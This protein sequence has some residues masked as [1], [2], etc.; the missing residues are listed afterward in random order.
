MAA[1]QRHAMDRLPG[2]YH[3]AGCTLASA[4][5]ACLAQGL[6]VEEAVRQA[7][8][9]TWQTLAAD[10][11]REWG[12]SYPTASSGLDKRKSTTEMRH[13]TRDPGRALCDHPDG[14]READL[15]ARAEATLKGGAKS[16]NTATR[17]ARQHSKST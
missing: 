1:A 5:A 12:N 11:G 16:S 13:E 9:Y 2:N 17:Q 7:Q 4:V 6:S 8:E 15:I 3:G 10:F 14:L